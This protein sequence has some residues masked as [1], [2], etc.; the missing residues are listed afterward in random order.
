MTMA[1]CGHV[2]GPALSPVSRTRLLLGVRGDELATVTHR[3]AIRQ[4]GIS[5]GTLQSM[6]PSAH[7]S[8]WFKPRATRV[9]R[10]PLLC[11]HAVWR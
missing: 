11:T 10:V 1:R 8:K 4:L 2:D 3:V 5:E 9:L 7:K 6:L